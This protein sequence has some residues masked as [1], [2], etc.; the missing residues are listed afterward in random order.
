M[1]LGWTLRQLPG[2]VFGHHFFNCATGFK[3]VGVTNM[4]GHHDDLLRVFGNFYT[5][6]GFTVCTNKQRHRATR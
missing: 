2:W 1:R 5:S 6:F 4:P 3:T